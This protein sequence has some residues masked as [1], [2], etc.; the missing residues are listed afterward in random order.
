MPHCSPVFL[1][2]L[3]FPWT[4]NPALLHTNI[5][6][7]ASA[8]KTSMLR[9]A[10]ISPLSTPSLRVDQCYVFKRFVTNDNKSQGQPAYDSC[11]KLVVYT[12]G[13]KSVMSVCKQKWFMRGRSSSLGVTR[14]VRR[15]NAMVVEAGLEKVCRPMATSD[16]FSIFK[17]PEW[18]RR[19]SNLGPPKRREE[20]HIIPTVTHVERTRSGKTGMRPT[21]VIKTIFANN[22]DGAV[23]TENCTG[24]CRS[25]E[26]NR[27][28]LTQ[29][30]C[31]N[32]I[33]IYASNSAQGYKA[34]PMGFEDIGVVSP[35]ENS[36]SLLS[37][38]CGKMLQG[39]SSELRA[40]HFPPL[41]LDGSWS[42]ALTD[43]RAYFSVP[44][45]DGS[46]CKAAPRSPTSA[47]TTAI[48]MSTQ[49]R[50]DDV[51]TYIDVTIGYRHVHFKPIEFPE[52][53][54]AWKIC[55]MLQPCRPNP[56]TD[57]KK[58]MGYKYI[59]R[60]SVRGLFAVVC[61]HI[62]M[63]SFHPANHYVHVKP[64]HSTVEYAYWSGGELK[65]YEEFYDGKLR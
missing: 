61:H 3:Q 11:R 33:N 29:W 10:Q 55:G 24:I 45:V 15:L 4:F 56:V 31:G 60:G 35:Q 39:K 9:A 28:W 44:N 22:G 13:M 34:E 42:V 57:K 54:Q 7:P 26:N 47:V 2:D 18:L 30:G 6:S 21:V 49:F 50:P 43:F 37:V 32:F 1:G 64:R 63:E 16:T 36:S 41:E 17:S 20:A 12:K 25:S 59:S 5:A 62:K 23:T 52:K 38:A 53:V 48:N 19:E 65:M 51:A 58:I 40:V 46:N 27:V 8:L 14:N